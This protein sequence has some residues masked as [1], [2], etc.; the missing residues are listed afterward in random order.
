VA[1]AALDVDPLKACLTNTI[2]LSQTSPS[3][4]LQSAINAADLARRENV[5]ATIATLKPQRVVPTTH[6]L[7]P[8]PARSRRLFM[9]SPNSERWPRLQL[10]HGFMNCFEGHRISKPQRLQQTEAGTEFVQHQ[11]VRT[12]VMPWRSNTAPHLEIISILVATQIKTVHN[13][14]HHRSFTCRRLLRTPQP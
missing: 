8:R 4:Y 9:S 12:T 5:V 10:T 3:R 6:V 13:H 2:H 7:G 14:R 1:S 11:S